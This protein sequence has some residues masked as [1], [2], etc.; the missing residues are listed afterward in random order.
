MFLFDPS[1]GRLELV[2]Q[3]GIGLADMGT[4]IWPDP[5]RWL[6]ATLGTLSGQ[7]GRARFAYLTP[8]DR[9]LDLYVRSAIGT[10]VLGGF[11]P[12][13]RMGGSA[14]PGMLVVSVPDEA[15]SEIYVID[16]IRRTG[17]DQPALRD[18]ESGVVPLRL[19][20]EEGNPTGILYCLTRSEV[21]QADIDAC[22]GLFRVELA[23]G[24]VEQIVP[25]DLAI[26]ALSPDMRIAALAST[27]RV[28]PEVHVRNLE[29]G[30][31]LV[32]RSEAGVREVRFGAL[33]PVGARLAWVSLSQGEGGEDLQAVSLAS[34]GGGP[35]TQLAIASLSEAV[36]A[37]V[38][39]V[40][41]VGWLD[42]ARLLLELSTPRETALYVLL[43]DEGRMDRV[44][45]GRL[46][47]FVYR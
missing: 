16:P 40:R 27:G 17:A 34:T 1:N 31:E 20:I 3:D 38:T 21:E 4:I 2:G 13:A 14:P 25:S 11:P 6:R 28:P 42:E 29:S 23:S 44:A 5:E 36:N 35:V 24:E 33:S 32:L 26:I 18:L 22:Y 8:S 7:S 39:S 15:G 12:E 43:M 46:A 9:G 19:Q 41:P 45:S 47:G 30:T 37:Q 10:L